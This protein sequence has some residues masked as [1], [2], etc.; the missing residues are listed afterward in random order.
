MLLQ[1]NHQ[2]VYKVRTMKNNQFPPLSE[3]IK[4]RRLN[5]GL[6]GRALA[7]KIGISHTV[8]FVIEN[9]A[10]ASVKAC[11]KIADYYRVPHSDVLRMNGTLQEDLSTE[12]EPIIEGTVKVMKKH[13]KAFQE[14]V[15][16]YALHKER[17]IEES[18]KEERRKRN[19][20]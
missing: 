20:S 11:E 1:N 8:L 12:G 6:S 13:G 5:E 9:G 7:G 17:L 3:W 15:R 16:Q 10:K 18:E 4:E 14:D 2:F 19:R